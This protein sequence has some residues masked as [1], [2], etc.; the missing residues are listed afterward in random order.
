MITTHQSLPCSCVTN[1]L[2]L[3]SFEVFEDVSVPSEVGEVA[4]SDADSG[5]LGE[6]LY[7]ISDNDQS[8]FHS[9]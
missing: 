9:L 6:V 4:A 2:F 8:V 1:I 3:N 5:M 7:S